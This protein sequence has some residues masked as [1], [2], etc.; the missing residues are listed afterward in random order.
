MNYEVQDK[1][2]LGLTEW[3]EK[4]PHFSG[5]QFNFDFNQERPI[6]FSVIIPTNIPEISKD[7]VGTDT[8]QIIFW[9]RAVRS[10]G[11]DIT[12]NINNV[13]WFQD[14]RNYTNQLNKNKDFPILGDNK[15]VV[16]V[17]FT[18]DGYI[19]AQSGQNGTYQMQ[20]RVIYKEPELGMINTKISLPD[21]W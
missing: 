18:T 11:D 20:G 12:N 15:E 9:I 14:V 13:G 5:G 2:Y 1:S 21:N 4:F 19:N 6:N 17:E 10:W 3:I 8:K 16:R 7:I